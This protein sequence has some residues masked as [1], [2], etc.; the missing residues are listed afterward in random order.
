MRRLFE[1]YRAVEK[2]YYKRTGIFPIMHTVVIRRDIHET[3]PWVARSLYDAF[4]AA[5]RKGRE[6]LFVDRFVGG[7]AALDPG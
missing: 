1:D 4:E 2:D 6:G 7:L 5:K 3:N